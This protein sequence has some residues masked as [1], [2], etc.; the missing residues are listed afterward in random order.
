MSRRLLVLAAV[1]ATILSALLAAPAQARPAKLQLTG[2]GDAVVPADGAATFT[3]YLNGTP[4]SGRAEGR[5]EP[6][7][8][9]LPIVGTCEEA[10]ARLYVHDGA[11]R[12]VDLVAEAGQVCSI[13][14]P[15]GTMQAFDGHFAVVSTSERK[16]RRVDGPLQVRLLGEQSDIYATGG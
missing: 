11:G 1:A 7:D 3:A 6:A 13:W 5:L 16:L 12:F 4:L 8:G 9:T 10:T 2:L 14:L 15:L